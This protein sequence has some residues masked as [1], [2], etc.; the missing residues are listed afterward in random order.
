MAAECDGLLEGSDEVFTIRTGSQ[1]SAYLPAY[2]GW[3]LIV[4]IG[5]QLPE[6]IHTTAFAM[7]MVLRRGPGSFLWCHRLFLGHERES[8]DF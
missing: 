3:E 4:D 6:K 7:R 5:G 1:M 2:I 8:P